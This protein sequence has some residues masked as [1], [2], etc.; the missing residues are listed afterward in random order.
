MVVEKL[1]SI[2]SAPI[3]S[4]PPSDLARGDLTGD[5][6]VRELAE[7]LALRNGFYAFESAL[8]VFPSTD[9][10]SL[11]QM[12]IQAWNDHQLWRNWYEAR[13]DG[14]LFFA[15]DILGV[16]FAIR[17]NDIVT[18]NPE[19]G[20]IEWLTASIEDWV[21][22]ILTDYEELTGFPLAHAWQVVHGPIPNGKRLVPKVPF[23]LGGKYE[24]A[25]LF[26]MDALEGMRYRGELWQQI[27]N[28]PDGAQ[29]RLKALPSQ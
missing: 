21:K 4:L 3:V 9:S 15:E 13:T 28:L 17:G 12:G 24:V 19:S 27:R 23:I 1:L 7:M 11:A 25:N 29:V 22:A 16:Q 20:E 26:A 2:A 10:S 8:H 18:F 14:L 5:P 6:R